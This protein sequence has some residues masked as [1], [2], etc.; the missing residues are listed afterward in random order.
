MNSKIGNF[1]S[2]LLSNDKE[3]YGS[4]V[5]MSSL[6][7]SEYLEVDQFSSNIKK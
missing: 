1:A 2:R 6:S 5:I 3:F 7:G 4:T